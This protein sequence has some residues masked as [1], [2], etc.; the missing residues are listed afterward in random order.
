MHIREKLQADQHLTELEKIL[1]GNDHISKIKSLIG[2]HRG[3]IEKDGV[4]I[5]V[6]FCYS[7]DWVEYITS[8]DEVFLTGYKNIKPL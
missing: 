1:P 8:D 2:I 5:Q 6:D 4:E 3:L 7:R